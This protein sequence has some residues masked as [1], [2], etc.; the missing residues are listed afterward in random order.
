MLAECVL[1]QDQGQ[2]AEVDDLDAVGAVPGNHLAHDVD[3]VPAHRRYREAHPHHRRPIAV[4][5]A[6]LGVRP[7]EVGG[8]IVFELGW[9]LPGCRPDGD[10]DLG[11]H[12]ACGL[13]RQL[14]EIDPLGV[15]RLNRASDVLVALAREIV[16]VLSRDRADFRRIVHQI[17][18]TDLPVPGAEVR[19]AERLEVLQEFL[20]RRGAVLVDPTEAV[21]RGNQSLRIALAPVALDL[22][23]FVIGERDQLDIH[24]DAWPADGGL[25]M[26]GI[27]LEPPLGNVE[28]LAGEVSAFEEHFVHVV[29]TGGIAP[30]DKRPVAG[31]LQTNTVLLAEGEAPDAAEPYIHGVPAFLTQ[32][33]CN[34][35]GMSVGQGS[36]ALAGELLGLVF[37]DLPFRPLAH[38]GKGRGGLYPA[39]VVDADR[40]A[41]T[42][43]TV[44]IAIRFERNDGKIIGPQLAL[45]EP[46]GDRHP[47]LRGLQAGLRLDLHLE[48][49]PVPRP[50]RKI[51]EV[52]GVVIVGTVFVEHMN[53]EAKVACVARLNP[54][55]LKEAADHHGLQSV[56]SQLLTQMQLLALTLEDNAGLALSRAVPINTNGRGI[57][58]RELPAGGQPIGLDLLETRVLQSRHVRGRGA[59]RQQEAHREQSRAGCHVG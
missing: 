13:D 3:Q 47:K 7:V 5:A 2:T 37:E 23:R 26:V 59:G 18:A 22:C 10:V 46:S 32:R 19:I 11:V 52:M 54:I 38:I 45:G 43:P 39:H 41:G 56:D 48:P 12:V 29:V 9:S 16:D 53:I 28:I 4:V 55:G 50:G 24:D 35:R 6:P 1:P 58:R 25:A 20:L 31:Q 42:C 27:S 33:Q 51:D 49:P 21:E 57:A 40:P 44:D 17:G 30:R 36:D 34:F 14:R 8:K 15:E